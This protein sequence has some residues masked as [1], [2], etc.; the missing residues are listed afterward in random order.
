MK[1]KDKIY[2]KFDDFCT[3]FK[4]ESIKETSSFKK[5]VTHSSISKKN[6]YERMEFLGDA[7]L[8]FCISRILF[9][10][11]E[12]K[13]E[14][15]LSKKKS[16]L[17]SRQVCRFVAKDIGLDSEI[18]KS[19]NVNIDYIIADVLESL[20][21]SIYYEFNFE[22]VFEIVKVIFEKYSNY[23]QELD[24]KTKLQ[25]IAQK[26]YKKLPTYS[27]ISQTGEKHN[28]VF[29]ISISCGDLY[30]EGIGNSKKKAEIKAAEKMLSLLSEKNDEDDWVILDH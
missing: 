4:I 29:K 30:V 3:R 10:K 11:E 25:E 16:F 17:C 20:L 15:K 21:C 28:P 1:K 12:N 24:P 22:K 13:T 5:A 8:N 14:G 18:I 7:I 2:S 23:S 27:L 19:K 26:N 9:E 6:N